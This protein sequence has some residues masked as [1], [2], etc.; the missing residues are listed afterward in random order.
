MNTQTLHTDKQT[1]HKY[2]STI[3]ARHTHST[4]KA[5]ATR[6]IHVKYL[7]KNS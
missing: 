5:F 1:L 3:T 2:A 7:I 6:V 4:N